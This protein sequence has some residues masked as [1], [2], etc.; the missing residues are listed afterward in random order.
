MKSKKWILTIIAILTI[1]CLTSA[2]FFFCSQ[3]E[4]IGELDRREYFVSEDFY[5]TFLSPEY[6]STNERGRQFFNNALT[7][8]AEP[9]VPKSIFEDLAKV[10]HAEI[11]SYIRSEYGDL[12]RF[13]FA[14]SFTYDELWE[15]SNQ[16]QE[17]DIIN[18]TKINTVVDGQPEYFTPNDRRWDS[19]DMEN[20]RGN[21]WGLE[22]VRAPSAWVYR[23]EMDQVGVLIFDAG[24]YANHEDLN[25]QYNMFRADFH[26]THVAGIIGADFNNE[27]G[28]SG[29]A[30]NSRLYGFHW[31]STVTGLPIS[32]TDRL[33]ILQYYVRRYGVNVINI[34][35]N[36]GNADGGLEDEYLAFKGDTDAIE[37][38]RNVA[39]YYEKRL[40]QLIMDNYEFLIVTSAGN[41]YA[42]HGIEDV[43]KPLVWIQN[44]EVR[45]RIITVGATQR[46]GNLADFSQRG[47]SMDVSAPGVGI[48][49]T[50][51]VTNILGRSRYRRLNGTSMSA[52]FVSGL[53][54]MIFGINPELTGADVKEIIVRTADESNHNII[55]AAEAVRMAIAWED[56]P[57]TPDIDPYYLYAEILKQYRMIVEKEYFMDWEWLDRTIEMQELSTDWLAWLNWQASMIDGFVPAYYAFYDIN[58]DGIPNLILGSG[59]EQRSTVLGIYTWVD[60]ETYLLEINPHGSWL[61]ERTHVFISQ[62]GIIANSGSS[63]ALSGATTFYQ[64]SLDGRG[65]EIVDELW[66]DLHEVFEWD[67][68]DRRGFFRNDE[69]ITEVEY[70]E[71]FHKHFGIL[72][73]TPDIAAERELVFE[74]NSFRSTSGN[75]IYSSIPE[76]EHTDISDNWQEWFSISFGEWFGS[77]PPEAEGFSG[78]DAFQHPTDIESWIVFPGSELAGYVRLPTDYPVVIFIPVSRLLG[79]PSTS[80]EELK[81]IF[82]ETFH[83]I[84]SNYW[85]AWEVQVEV[86]GF[87]MG[88]LLENENDANIRWVEIWRS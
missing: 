79:Q 73:Q 35:M 45:N 54:T 17:M 29:I 48:Y 75:N 51:D 10:Y 40:L 55:N 76:Q 63:S 81:Y 21:N 80:V 78:G 46:D 24:F 6:V 53:A 26:G 15:L 60:G 5:F 2:L 68:D 23:Y 69:Q 16:F 57:V 20:P 61:G 59:T 50:Y 44:E 49:S 1:I 25:F 27:I 41:R 4:Q 33:N 9:D 38:M 28:I 56:A 82:D 31:L 83:M 12:Y 72:P 70:N 39:S 66:H 13:T 47:N 62:D 14:R 11:T 65:I 88:F 58:G 37:R 84:Y 7:V 32:S 19:W 18:F 30:P 64:I 43:M 87:V 71:I 85:D 77:N 8:I 52:P 36:W 22:T 3:S 67:T 34:S 86:D 42:T 74:W